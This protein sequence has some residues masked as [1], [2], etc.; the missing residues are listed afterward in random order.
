VARLQSNDANVHGT[1]PTGSVGNPLAVRVRS[2]DQSQASVSDDFTLE[3]ANVFTGTGG[4][5]TLV[6]TNSADLLYGLDGDAGPDV[7]Y[8]GPDNDTYVVDQAGD[9]VT[10]NPNEGTDTVETVINCTLTGNVEILTLTGPIAKSSFH[11]LPLLSGTSLSPRSN[12]VQAIC[13][14]LAFRYRLEI[15]EVFGTSE[16]VLNPLK[17]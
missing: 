7:T 14:A 11:R 9:V 6:A 15:L 10:E 5:D 12:C 16:M 17:D 8:G 4:A 2:T 1:P 3:I 13:A